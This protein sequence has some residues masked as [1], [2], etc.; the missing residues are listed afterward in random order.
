MATD[1]AL[2]ARFTAFEVC[3]EDRLQEL[4]REFKRSRSDSPNKTQHHESSNLK[5]SRSEKYDHGQDT[6]YSCMRVEFHRWEDGDPIGWISL[7]ENFFRFHRT[8][9]ESKVEITF[10]QLEGDTI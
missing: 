4:L 1:N 5:G 7:A 9:E 10:I 3:I 8:P 6:G 2:H